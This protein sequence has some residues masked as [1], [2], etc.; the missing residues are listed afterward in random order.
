MLESMGSLIRQLRIKKGLTQSELAQKAGLSQPVIGQ[1]ELDKRS[2]KPETLHKLADALGCSI[3]TFLSYKNVSNDDI[4][5]I[6]QYDNQEILNASRQRFRI[7]HAL[8]FLK[9]LN[10]TFIE[11]IIFE[12]EVFSLNYN[13]DSLGIIGYLSSQ[14]VDGL[15]VASARVYSEDEIIKRIE[16]AKSSP[17]HIMEISY[18]GET[19]Q[20]DY[21]D[22][23]KWINNFIENTRT[24]VF[25]QLHT[26]T[27]S[28]IYMDEISK[29]IEQHD[30]DLKQGNHISPTF[31]EI[32][33][34]IRD[35]DADVTLDWLQDKYKDDITD[36]QLLTLL[37]R[38]YGYGIPG[39][40][41][42][43]ICKGRVS[44]KVLQQLCESNV[45]DRLLQKLF[46]TPISL[47][48]LRKIC[49]NNIP[50]QL[51]QRLYGDNISNEQ[52]SE[53]CDNVIPPELINKLYASQKVVGQDNAAS[54]TLTE[55]FNDF[56]H[57]WD[58]IIPDLQIQQTASANIPFEQLCYYTKNV[59]LSEFFRLVFGESITVQQLQKL[60]KNNI[61]YTPPKNR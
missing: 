59:I 46:G 40:T 3:E 25:Q 51:L 22:Y 34:L 7:S 2:P 26:I 52:L 13:D 18:N 29:A 23:L 6:K 9:T 4:S 53:I 49:G 30:I 19:M 54:S 45:S 37:Q 61:F 16:N 31:N 27:S 32:D 24:N 17:K 60:Y 21:C 57:L 56:K 8:A 43:E 44:E 42:V 1:Y 41:L 5:K 33:R 12:D 20:L 14:C 58:D 39:Q 35:T 48:R 10:F 11:K 15:L 47:K 28:P 55:T 36:K 38:I 50:I